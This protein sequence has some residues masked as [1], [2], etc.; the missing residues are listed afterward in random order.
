MLSSLAPCRCCPL[1]T[2][3]IIGLSVQYI[4]RA[5]FLEKESGFFLFFLKTVNIRYKIFSQM[6]FIILIIYG[7]NTTAE[8]KKQIRCSAQL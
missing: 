3:Q 5:A 1:S 6:F 2:E 4:I 7:F 8:A